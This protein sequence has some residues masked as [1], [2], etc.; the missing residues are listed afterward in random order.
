MSQPVKHAAK[1]EEPEFLMR[2]SSKTS[3]AYH[4]IQVQ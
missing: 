4:A 1:Y 3:A 2:N